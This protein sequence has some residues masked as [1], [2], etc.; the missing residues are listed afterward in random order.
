MICLPPCIGILL[1]TR[2]WEK[3]TLFIQDFIL[4]GCLNRTH[5]LACPG[6]SCIGIDFLTHQQESHTCEP[7][8]NLHEDG[9][10]YFI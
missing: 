9:K 2:L 5:I 10:F 6:V 3:I 8:V 7:L 4:L 1:K